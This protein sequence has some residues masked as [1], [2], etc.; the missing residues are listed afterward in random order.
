LKNL[1]ECE[2][3]IETNILDTKEIKVMDGYYLKIEEIQK[4]I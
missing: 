3:S 1:I 2:N 4:S